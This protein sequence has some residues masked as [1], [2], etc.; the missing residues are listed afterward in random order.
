MG[1]TGAGKSTILQVLF[2][3]TDAHKGKLIIDGESIYDVGLHTLRKK[4]AYIPQMPFM[5]QGTIRENLDP[6]DDFGEERVIATLKECQLYD[7]VMNNCKDGINTKVSGESNTLF[8]TGQK[9]L[10]CLGRA[11]IKKTKVL[12]LDEATANVDMETDNLIQ[13]MLK[14]CFKDCTVLVIAHRLATVMDSEAILV[15]DQGEGIEYNH[16]FKLLVKD[17]SDTE[18][19]NPEIGRAHV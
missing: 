13:R 2:R 7:H 12:V 15:M 14:E 4:I 19:T 16:P 5:I 8:S 3:L 17:E 10:L 18:I 11:L 6:F 9:Q 1:R